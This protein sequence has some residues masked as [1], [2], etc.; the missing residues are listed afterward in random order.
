MTTVAHS[1]RYAVSRLIAAATT[2][3]P[4]PLSV[5]DP[6]QFIGGGI[7]ILMMPSRFYDDEDRRLPEPTVVLTEGAIAVQHARPTDEQAV[8]LR[9]LGWTDMGDR[10]VY[11]CPRD[12]VE[13]SDA[14]LRDGAR[15]RR[16]KK[17]VRK[18]D[19]PAAR[20]FWEHAE[21]CAKEVAKWPAWKR[22]GINVADE[23]E[24]PRERPQPRGGA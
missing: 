8:A 14:V 4:A 15:V 20:R 5:L 6:G 10:W 9:W 23:R 1:F 3:A 13:G 17:I 11:W 22:V 24:L 7:M 18:A 19:T 16:R 21:R 12:E 2:R